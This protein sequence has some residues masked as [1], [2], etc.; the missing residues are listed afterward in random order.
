MTE[1]KEPTPE[2]VDALR[3]H[4]KTLLGQQLS[5]ELK[6]QVGEG[7]KWGGRFET[8]LHNVA[9]REI[10]ERAEIIVNLEEQE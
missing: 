2:A 4:P 9:S 6:E 3:L 8:A 5:D 1:R 10:I 7:K